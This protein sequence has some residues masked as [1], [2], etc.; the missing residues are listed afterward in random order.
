M[1]TTRGAGVFILALLAGCTVGPNYH[2]PQTAMPAGWVPPTTA[3]TTQQSVAT[4]EPVNLVEWW[5]VFNDPMLNNLVTRAV[6]SNLSLRQ[7]EARIR[8]ARAS[9][10]VVGSALWPSAD[11]SGSYRRSGVGN[12]G[13]RD[14]FTAGLDASW[15]IDVFGGTR[16]SIE[17]AD[18]DL[19]STIEDRNDVL[20]SLIAEVALNYIDLRSFQHEI[21]IAR[22]NLADQRS[23]AD[24][25]RQRRIAGFVSALDTANADASVASTESQIPSLEAAVRQTIY[26]LSVL[27]GLEPATL[28][29]ELN[30]PA[31]IPLPPAQVPVGLPSDLL[32][33]RPDIRRA[34]SNLHA[35]TASIGVA[36]SDL[37]PR[38][39][40]TGS[41]GTSNNS[42]NGLLDRNR[43][44]WSIGPGVS[45]NIFDA[46]RIRGN[47]EL[48]NAAAQ[49]ALIGYQNTILVALQD[50]ENSL[51]SYEKEQEHRRSLAAAVDA[52]RQAVIISTQLYRA[53]NTDFLNV[54]NAQR[55]LLGTEDALAQSDR[56]IA[57]NLVSLYKALGGGW[58]SQDEQN[59]VAE[60]S[61]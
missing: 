37:F 51:I 38:F 19:Q 57:T 20:I 13:P 47:I 12:T 33:R 22:R 10:Q 53:G 29:K 11:A 7:A 41:V 40:L 4:S 39:S 6:K 27:L 14:L 52:N 30:E 59:Q 50:V 8:Q 36:T 5:T 44:T 49:E 28:L 15:E 1:R 46:G 18:A 35:A 17:A 45:W 43:A 42:L 55:S 32:R 25:T 24:L 56:T 23:S 3:P 9:R 31:P 54:L 60:T 61:K 16:R 2:A 48:R 58:G 21:D 34:E 26:S